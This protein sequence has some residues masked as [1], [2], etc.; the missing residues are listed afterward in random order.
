MKIFEI[1]PGLFLWSVLTFLILMAALYKFAFG[2]LM[3]MQKKR[4]EEI[5]D[6][7]VEAE[8]LRDEAHSLLDDYKQQLAVARL[9]AEEILERSRKVGES[10]KNEMLEEAR[11]QAERTLERSR[12]QIQRETRQALQQ[13]KGNPAFQSIPVVMATTEAGK[14]DIL[15]AIAA[16]ASG[17]IV[18]PFQKET[19]IVKIKEILGL[20]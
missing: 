14:A 8:R 18:K 2:P 1:D 7:I 15:K 3:A 12:E 19:L 9:E 10:T 5:H 16:G 4:Q 17:Y 6:S 20:P 13:I 11:L